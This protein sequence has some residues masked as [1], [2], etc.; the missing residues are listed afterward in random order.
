MI[1]YCTG[2]EKDVEARLV[3]GAAVYPHRRDLYELPFWICDTCGNWVGCHH[4]TEDPTKPLG[5][6]PTKKLKY[7]RRIIHDSLDP[8]WKEGDW[9]RKT[10]YAHLN[11]ELGY[12]Y[13]TANIRSVEEANKVIEVLQKLTPVRGR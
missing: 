13:H 3:N 6:I 1:I 12:N 7:L 5:V 11:S 9:N 8:L 10:L 2:C 4:K